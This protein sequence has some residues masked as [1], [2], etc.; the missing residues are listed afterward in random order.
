MS[1]QHE[2]SPSCLL[3]LFI[4][5]KHEKHLK[6]LCSL[7]SSVIDWLKKKQI[8]GSKLIIVLNYLNYKFTFKKTC[9]Y[10]YLGS[11]Y[12]RVAVRY[13][14]LTVLIWICRVPPHTH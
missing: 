4:C 3:L 2:R 6:C 11:M 14:K 8:K 13:V 5:I 12:F 9:A 7:D 10:T 1:R